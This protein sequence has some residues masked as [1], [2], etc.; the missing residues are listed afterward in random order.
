M[1][2]LDR[3]IPQIDRV[4]MEARYKELCAIRDKVTEE[5][6]PLRDELTLKA[7][8]AEAARV[9]SMD[10]AKRLYTARGGDKWFSL[11][12]EIGLLAKVLNG[13][14]PATKEEIIAAKSLV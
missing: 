6:K 7:N 3:Y 11:K 13:S 14:V 10:V 1:S 9:A 12:K 4:A 8:E 5:V 2:A